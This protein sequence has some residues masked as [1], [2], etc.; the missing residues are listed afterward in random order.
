MV[1]VLSATV[2]LS[3]SFPPVSPLICS[4]LGDHGVHH[5]ILIQGLALCGN[6]APFH[7][8]HRHTHTLQIVLADIS[9]YLKQFQSS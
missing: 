2:S 5:Q 4:A 7:R 8:F 6:F 9:S 3:R 1:S